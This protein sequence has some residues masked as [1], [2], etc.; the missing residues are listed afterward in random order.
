MAVENV[1]RFHKFG[2]CKFKSDC[3]NKHIEEICEEKS[4]DKKCDKRHP[5]PCKYFVNFGDCKWLGAYLGHTDN[6][7]VLQVLDLQRIHIHA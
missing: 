7:G 5:K 2:F 6:H 4:C 3:K 1:C